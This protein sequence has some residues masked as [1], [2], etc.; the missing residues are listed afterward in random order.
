MS[1][2]VLIRPYVTEKTTY[3]MEE[4]KYSFICGLDAS[5]P[6]IRQAIEERYPGVDVAKV[7]T[8]VVPGKR[9]RQFRQGNMI[10]GRTSGFKKAIVE[11]DPDG[12]Q[13]DFFEGI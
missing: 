2:R 1:K 8:Q 7:R 13:I 3:Q 4:G 6:E 9:R 12:E 5:K 10:E 11:L